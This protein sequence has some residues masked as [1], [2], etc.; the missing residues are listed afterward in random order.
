MPL[1]DGRKSVYVFFFCRCNKIETSF[2]EIENVSLIGVTVLLIIVDRWRMGR[3]FQPIHADIILIQ[4][5]LPLGA[6]RTFSWT[7]HDR[8]ILIITDTL[9]LDVERFLQLLM[10]CQATL[11][12]INSASQKAPDLLKT[13]SGDS[14]LK[15][16]N[17]YFLVFRPAR[18]LPKTL[19]F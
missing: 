8:R 4:M 2:M 5:T 6:S 12:F 3:P 16:F 14:S 10:N 1:F 18:S 11:R 13:P 15:L 17:K 7:F 9:Q 19:N